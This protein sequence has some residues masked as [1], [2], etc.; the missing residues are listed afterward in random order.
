MKIKVKDYLWMAGLGAAA[1]LFL[2][3]VFQASFHKY[4]SAEIQLAEE[5]APRE[6]RVAALPSRTIFSGQELKKK[7]VQLELLGTIMGRNSTAFIY[8]PETQSS[9]LYKVNNVVDGFKVAE[10][11]SGKV[12]LEK[13]GSKHELFLSSRRVKPIKENESF[14]AKDESGTMIIS[15]FQ[16]MAQMFKANEI[17]SK[18]KI[19]PLADSAANKLKGF[20][21]DNVPS[22]SIIEEAGIKSGD[23]IYS[24]QGQRLQSMQ[25]ALSMFNR[26]Q[27]QSRVE[28]VLLR[29]DQPVTLKYEIKN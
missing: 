2:N 4:R 28:V 22:G 10:V 24:V 11:L 13:D 29:N 5:T 8:N 9:G 15:K 19:M 18:I 6:A 7:S 21:V 23:V 1:L 17:L 3:I 26:I 27:S 12:I 14:V 25:D 16:M 20:R